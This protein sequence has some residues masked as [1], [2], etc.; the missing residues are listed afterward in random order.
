MAT[1][2]SP[3]SRAWAGSRTP[4]SRNEVG[5]GR[6]PRGSD[7]LVR[8]P[9]RGHRPPARELAGGPAVGPPLLGDARPAAH[10]RRAGRA[11][12]AG[13]LLR[14]GAQ[15]RALSR[16]AG[17]ARIDGARGR[18]PRLVPRAVGR[19]RAGHGGRAAPEG[20]RRDGGARPAATGL[21]TA[22]WRPDERVPEGTERA[23]VHLLLA[24]R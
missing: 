7:R 17:R 11:R 21:S 12:P 20:G 2:W 3:R 13:H 5:P 19:A 18:L 16:H 6:A 8:Q 10:P 24:G 14:R 15:H 1:A 22:R 9:R 23:W 4:W